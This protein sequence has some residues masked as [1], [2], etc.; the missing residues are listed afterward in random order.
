MAQGKTNAETA[1]A[2]GFHDES[3]FAK[4]FKRWTGMTPTEFQESKSEN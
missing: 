2:L 4:A 3:A 1:T